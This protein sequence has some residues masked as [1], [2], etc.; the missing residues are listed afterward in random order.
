MHLRQRARC[1]AHAADATEA[2]FGDVHR[3]FK[4]CRY[5]FGDL[6]ALL[7]IREE[8]LD[9][10]VVHRQR[11]DLLGRA[12]DQTIVVVVEHLRAAAAKVEPSGLVVLDAALQADV[13]V[14]GLLAARKQP[15]VDPCRLLDLREHL[16]LVTDAAQRRRRKAGKAVAACL[17]A[18]RLHASQ[19]RAEAAD[20]F[21]RQHA[22][23][24]VA[25]D[26]GKFLLVDQR[27]KRIV[28]IDLIDHRT[29]R[30]GTNIN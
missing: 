11:P 30:V 14:V 5:I 12:R 15:D 24:D 8:P 13:I 28:R 4:L 25:Q 3:A 22:V 23:L 6:G 17:V 26:F 2:F 29:H 16:I 18:H 10:F 9:E 19:N 20:P 1:A 27:A 7:G 21:C